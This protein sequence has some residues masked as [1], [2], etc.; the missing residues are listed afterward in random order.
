MKD[1]FG[2][3]IRICDEVAFITTRRTIGLGTVTAFTPTMIL[4][5][6]A[7]AWRGN[8]AGRIRR[9]SRHPNEVIVKVAARRLA[10]A[11]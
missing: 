2:V 4:I 6:G 7:M 3:E 8:Q 5:N 11:S 1:F 9:T 10:K